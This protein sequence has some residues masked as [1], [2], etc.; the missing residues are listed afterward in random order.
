MIT[1]NERKHNSSNSGYNWKRERIF[2]YFVSVKQFLSLN[3][4]CHCRAVLLDIGVWLMVKSSSYSYQRP[5]YTQKCKPWSTQNFISWYMEQHV[6]MIWSYES[7]FTVIPDTW[8]FSD[9]FKSYLRFKS[10]NGS[11]MV[12]A[13]VSDTLTW[14]R[15][16]PNQQIMLLQST[17]INSSSKRAI[18]ADHVQSPF[19]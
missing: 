14:I 13:A 11:V 17:D 9:S 15:N 12:W 16:D 5:Q 6:Y 8:G 2:L 1:Q 7:L 19:F 18:H 4:D 10:S 3:T